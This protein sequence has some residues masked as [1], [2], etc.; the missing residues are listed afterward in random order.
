MPFY[1]KRPV[2]IE[3][4]QLIAETID[5]IS[6]WIAE[7]GYNVKYYTK[8]P[9]RAVSGIVIETL[10]GNMEAS[11]FDYIIKGVSGEFYPCKPDIFRATYCEQATRED[12]LELFSWDES[13]EEEGPLPNRIQTHS[14]YWEWDEND[15]CFYFYWEV[16]E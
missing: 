1:K 15:A 11:F 8:P 9:M 14:G 13:P 6:L 4:R 10:E 7:N 2:T 5:S 12:I 3:A 16:Y